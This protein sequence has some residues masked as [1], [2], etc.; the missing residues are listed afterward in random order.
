MMVSSDH[1]ALQNLVAA[2]NCRE[3]HR[4]LFKTGWSELPTL[5]PIGIARLFV[6]INT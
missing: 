5:Q 1:R 4:L 2:V 6:A 3:R